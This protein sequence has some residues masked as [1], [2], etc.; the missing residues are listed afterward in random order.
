VVTLG[1]NATL[2]YL[3]D[4]VIPHSGSI[5]HQA[6]R[7]EIGASSRAIFWD[8]L[9]AGRV[10]RGERWAFN[11]LDSRLE[12]YM[13]GRPIFLNRTWI[14]PAY[15]SSDRLGITDNFDYLA[16]L[17]VVSGRAESWDDVVS[18]MNSA[19]ATMPAIR[20][21]A[22]TLP[23]NGCIVKLLARRASDM[24]RAQ[25]A[26]WNVAREMILGANPLDLRKY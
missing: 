15:L 5:F 16:T 8:A 22:S 20:A 10:A 7:V 24:T 14:R 21:G 4:H 18:A 2:E 3:P 6:L 23:N 12:I 19:L 25:S 1:E 17:L 13:R 26:L 9:A 11:E